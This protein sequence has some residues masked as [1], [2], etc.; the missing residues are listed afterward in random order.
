MRRCIRTVLLIVAA[1][2]AVA[3]LAS[4]VRRF[5]WDWKTDDEVDAIRGG[6]SIAHGQ[7]YIGVFD[8][9]ATQDQT[10][11]LDDVVCFDALGVH[12]LVQE[13]G[14]SSALFED[15]VV[16]D[17]PAAV[18]YNINFSGWWV[19]LACG[20]YPCTAFVIRRIRTARRR[21]RG[22]CVHCGYDQRGNPDEV[23]PECGRSPR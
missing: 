1:L 12:V 9:S 17:L 14:P 11:R 18:T 10:P 23:C 22:L 8:P 20:A 13:E 4:G 7:V 2:A 3:T 6:C 19:V 16:R 5:S 15:G 21:R